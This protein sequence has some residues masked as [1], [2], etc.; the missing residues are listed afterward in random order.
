QNLLHQFHEPKRFD[1]DRVTSGLKLMAFGMFKKVVIA[2]RL[3][4]YVNLVYG[5]PENYAGITYAIATL[6]FAFQ[7]YC[8]FSG[9]SDIAL[10]AAEVMGFS[11]MRN[12]RQPYFSK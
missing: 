10:G 2:D 7:I 12:F 8:D 3:A 11:L 6:F 1:A 4:Q 5:H 9:Y